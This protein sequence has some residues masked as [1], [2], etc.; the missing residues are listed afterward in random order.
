MWKTMKLN[1]WLSVRVR[2]I[3]SVCVCV[4]SCF[5][6][7]RLFATLWTVACQ[8]PLSMGFSRQRESSECWSGLPCHP[9]GDLY[10]PGLNLSPLSPV[11]AGGFFTTRAT[12]QALFKVYSH[13]TLLLISR[14]LKIATMWNASEVCQHYEYVSWVRSGVSEVGSGEAR[15][16]CWE[17]VF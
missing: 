5:S 16:V 6:C 7:V 14:N 12:W 10:N 4:L 1:F 13:I 15:D 9:P 8:A 3:Q 11:L 2:F 17:C